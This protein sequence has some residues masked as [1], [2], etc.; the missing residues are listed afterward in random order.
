MP[1][2]LVSGDEACD[3]LGVGSTKLAEW[4]DDGTLVAE[5]ANGT[6]WFRRSDIERLA[7]HRP[8][9]SRRVPKLEKRAASAKEAGSP[10][11]PPD[12]VLE[13]A[14]L[15]GRFVVAFERGE[16]GPCPVCG[17]VMNPSAWP[18]HLLGHR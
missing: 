13:Q 4:L 11:A 3:I 5:G 7:A 9:K 10:A 16:H 1:D 12:E 17:E 8:P 18:A 6:I 2:E 14:L 15:L